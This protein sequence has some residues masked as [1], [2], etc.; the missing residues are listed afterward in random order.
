[1]GPIDARPTGPPG[2]PRVAFRLGLGEMMLWIA[3]IAACLAASTV[4]VPLGVFS[5]LIL[6]PALARTLRV[7]ALR[8]DLG[9]PTDAETWAFAAIGSTGRALG[10]WMFA[11]LAFYLGMGAAVVVLYVALTIASCFVTVATP[12]LNLIN[13]ITSTVMVGTGSVGAVVALVNSVRRFWPIR[14]WEV[15]RQPGGD[16][17]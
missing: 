16:R 17:R 8:K 3:A 1:M 13:L 2:R 9:R 6:A 10:S 15:G 5:F 12:Y 4:W 14:D 7:V 11:L